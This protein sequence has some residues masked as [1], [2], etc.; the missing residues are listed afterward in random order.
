[1]KINLLGATGPSPALPPGASH[2][3]LALSAV[4]GTSAGVLAGGLVVLGAKFCRDLVNPLWRGDGVRQLVQNADRWLNDP[5]VYDVSPSGFLTGAAVLATG[6]AAGTSFAKWRWYQHRLGL[7]QN[8]HKPEVYP[9]QMEKHIQEIIRLRKDKPEGYV[10][11]VKFRLARLRA[12]VAGVLKQIDELSALQ[13]EVTAN[14][15][16]RISHFIPGMTS[17]DIRVSRAIAVGMILYCQLASRLQEVD[18]TF[19]HHVDYA[20][21]LSGWRMVVSI[22]GLG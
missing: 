8:L 3:T 17:L 16:N 11:L 6:V 19:N 4:A 20:Q 22:L 12:I 15:I 2:R 21:K 5:R 10:E 14:G 9:E 7:I 1:M 18:P 13:N